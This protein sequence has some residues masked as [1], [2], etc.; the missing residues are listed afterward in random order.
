MEDPIRGIPDDLQPHWRTSLP[1]RQARSSSTGTNSSRTATATCAG[2]RTHLYLFDVA[3]KK[4]DPLTTGRFDDESPSWSPDGPRIAFV[5]A[6]GDGDVDTTNTDIWVIDA[7][8]VR[9]RQLTTS[10][11]EESGPLGRGARTARRSPICSA[12]R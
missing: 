2:A 5:R 11:A 1:E 6:T 3:T 10:T 8:P 4:V 9:S 7:T 12:T